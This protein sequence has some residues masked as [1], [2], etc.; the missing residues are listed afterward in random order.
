ML[1]GP[2]THGMEVQRGLSG[3][4]WAKQGNRR[5]RD[6]F[7]TYSQGTTK[8]KENISVKNIYVLEK[9]K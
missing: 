5:K 8:I 3:R 9:F 4:W 6:K 2:H 7:I 1:S